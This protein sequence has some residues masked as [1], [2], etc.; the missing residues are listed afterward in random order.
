VRLL[1][2][3][4]GEGAPA[5]G[6]VAGVLVRFA[7]PQPGQCQVAGP[8]TNSVGAPT[9]SVDLETRLFATP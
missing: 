4:V 7:R 8:A 3:T 2:A 9:A 6:N 5:T 1:S